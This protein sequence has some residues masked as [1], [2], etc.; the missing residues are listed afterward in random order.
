[1]GVSSG[2]TWFDDDS[3]INREVTFTEPSPSRWRAEK[4]LEEREVLYM[5]WEVK[6]AGFIPRA[7]GVFL[8]SNLDDPSM[9]AVLKVRLQ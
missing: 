6:D 2:I 3:W 8:C 1:M 9:V 7:H 5:E 4:K